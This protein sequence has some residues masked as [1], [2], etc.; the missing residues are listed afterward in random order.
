MAGRHNHLNEYQ[1][2]VAVAQALAVGESMG[3]LTFTHNPMGEV[4]DGIT[5]AKL[6]RMGTKAGWPDF[7]IIMS[8][9]DVWFLELKRIG[10][11]LS[12]TQKST[13]AVIEK[14]R[15]C[16]YV[17]KGYDEAME[18]LGNIGILENA[19]NKPKFV[20]IDGKKKQDDTSEGET[21]SSGKTSSLRE[22]WSQDSIPK[23]D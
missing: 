22:V 13:L 23:P 19:G 3:N 16:F 20:V 6:K 10:G 9:G 18:F 15:G 8:N 4:R 17:A 21:G 7:T 1:I 2:T 5:G 11:R 14:M 12:K